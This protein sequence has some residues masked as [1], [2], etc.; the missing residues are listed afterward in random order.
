MSDNMRWRYGDTNPVVAA[1]DSATVIEIGDNVYQNTDDAKPASDYTYADGLN[2]TQDAIAD[3]YLGVAM[4]RSRAADTDDIR[5]ATSGVF[6]F[7][8]ASSTFELGDVVGLD[9]N[10]DGDEL[11]DQ[12]VITVTDAARAIGTVAKRVATA[13]TTVLVAIKSNVMGGGV[14]GNTSSGA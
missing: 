1:V 10:S 14:T 3:E 13:A 6:E 12:K 5:V 11:E 2:A 9:D 7:T 4:Q 8:C